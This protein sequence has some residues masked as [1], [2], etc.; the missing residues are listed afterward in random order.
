MICDCKLDPTL[1]RRA[2]L[3]R[4]E[5]VNEHVYMVL[6]LNLILHHNWLAIS[7]LITLLYEYTPDCGNIKQ[8]SI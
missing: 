1:C 7:T 8:E 4:L 2:T 6:H 5:A 3:L